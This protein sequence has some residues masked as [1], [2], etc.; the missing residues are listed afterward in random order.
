MGLRS[1][2]WRYFARSGRLIGEISYDDKGLKHDAFFW[3]Y[4]GSQMEVRGCFSH[5]KRSGLWIWKPFRLSD[6]PVSKNGGHYYIPRS[7][8]TTALSCNVFFRSETY[9]EQG[10]LHGTQIVNRVL[11]FV[12]P[13]GRWHPA[14]LPRSTVEWN[15][16]Q[17]HGAVSIHRRNGS[18][19]CRI[20]SRGGK[21]RSLQFYRR[22]FF[23]VIHDNPLPDKNERSRVRQRP[24]SRSPTSRSHSPFSVAGKRKQRSRDRDW[25]QKRRRTYQPERA[26]KLL[27]VVD[28]PP[29]SKSYTFFATRGPRLRNTHNCSSLLRLSV[30]DP[31]LQSLKAVSTYAANCGSWFKNLGL[32][33]VPIVPLCLELGERL[34]VAT[35]SDAT[36]RF[37]RTRNGLRRVKPLLRTKL[38]HQ[39]SKI[40]PQRGGTQV[41]ISSRG[42]LFRF[43]Q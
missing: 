38:P 3:C 11:R 33:N 19:L 30:L 6:P 4:E 35:P 42:R 28:G 40:L 14:L 43:Q 17:W 7:D 9:D 31:S 26:R 20:Q 10:R 37:P 1:G 34:E 36:T 15:H 25:Y 41:W 16:D 5:G 32:D 21:I 39:T 12:D 22:G 2:K 18:L 13:S 23:A 24:I 8:H 29:R 27:M